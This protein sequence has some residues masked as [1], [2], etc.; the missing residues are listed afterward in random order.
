MNHARPSIESGV[1]LGGRWRL[2]TLI[3]AGGMGEVWRVHHDVMGR[4]AAAKLMQNAVVT[5]RERLLQEAR[6]LASIRHGAV[7]EVFD[8]GEHEEVPFYVMELLVG[9]TLGERI[10]S[11]GRLPAA[12]AVGLLVPVLDGLEAAHV[13]G[14]IHRDVKPENVFLVETLA[15]ERAKLV[16]F[17]V[18][19]VRNSKA[20]LTVAGELVGTPDYIAPE[21]I[22]GIDADARTDVWAL[23]ITLYESIFGKA[24]FETDNIHAT[25]FRVLND[26]PVRDPVAGVDDALWALL[27]RSLEKSPAARFQSASAFAAALRIWATRT[28]APSPIAPT[29]PSP[30]LS[31]AQRKASPTLAAEA[32]DPLRGSLD[33]I[34]RGKLT[35][36]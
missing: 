30:A 26:K 20:R 16:D 7:V 4:V 21:Q 29:L 14:V 23:G 2:E 27:L 24:P 1:V 34:F 12:A 31:S 10:R 35:P 22:R 33:A 17:G 25:L 5:G 3:G 9:R 8:Y 11:E 28:V 32:P 18:A 19:R 36:R 6:V 13:A 15:G